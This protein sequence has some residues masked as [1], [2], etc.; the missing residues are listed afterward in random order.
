MSA[1]DTSIYDPLIRPVQPQN[2]MDLLTKA[3]DLKTAIV[4]SQMAPIELQRQQE[5]AAQLHQKT[6]TAQEDQAD[7]QTLQQLYGDVQN[8]SSIAPEKKLEELRSRA[9]GKV[10]PRTLEA[11][12]KQIEDHQTAVQKLDDDHLKQV[13]AVGEEIGNTAAGILAADPQSRPALYAQERQRLIAAKVSTPDQIPEQYDENYL[14][15]AQAHAM[16]ATNAATA[17]ISRREQAN[18]DA[19][20]A[21]K[22][23]TDELATAAQ[24]I[25]G[26]Q[27]Q[28]GYD[29]WRNKLSPANKALT[30]ATFT[31]ANVATIKRMGLTANQQREADQATATAAETKRHNQAQ[32]TQAASKPTFSGD[33]RAALIAAKAKDP[34]NPTPEESAAAFKVLHPGTETKPVSKSALTQIEARKTNA[35]KDSKAKLDKDL[36]GV[37][38]GGKVLDQDAVDQAW[39]DHIQ[40]LQDAQTG[41]ENELTTATGGDVGHNDWADRLRVPGKGS[42]VPPESAAS[43]QGAQPTA[44][45]QKAGPA[46]PNPAAK[47][48]VS[49]YKVGQQVKLKSG[50]TVT[51]KSIDPET[52]NFEY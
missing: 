31:P 17:E 36:A 49:K 13:K 9:A 1:T 47:A 35:I 5:E 45:G 20:E 2:P 26:V 8:D 46:A 34:D 14:K 27:D 30:A 40:R 23:R 21:R 25:D 4:R 48:L 18:K 15:A 39:E 52:G 43:P 50:Q 37:T 29:A 3:T 38:A 12:S 42:V 32:E 51:I 6:Q 11:L 10:K 44:Q 33:M 28:A 19:D 24:T 16:G 41:Y 22:A 7:Q